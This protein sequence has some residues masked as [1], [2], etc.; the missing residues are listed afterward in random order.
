LQ[1]DGLKLNYSGQGPT[2]DCVVKPELVLPGTN[3]TSC[4]NRFVAGTGPPYTQKSGTSMSTPIVSGAVALL[5][6]KYPYMTP[7]QVKLRLY[8]RAVDLGLSSQKQGWG[9]LDMSRLL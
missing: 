4:S 9:T 7:V 8:E 5:L 6:S 1:Q 3:I 2:G